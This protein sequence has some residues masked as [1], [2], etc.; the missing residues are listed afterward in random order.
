MNKFTKEQYGSKR[1]FTLLEVM[2]SLAIVAITL[3]VVAGLRNRDIIYHHEIHKMVKATLLA[4][5]RMTLLEIA[6]EYPDFGE[7][8][9]QFEN[10]YEDFSWVQSTVPTPFEFVREIRVVVR[11]GLEPH[12]S[13]LLVSY[14]LE[15]DEI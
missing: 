15:E 4:Q 3:V 8:A 2:V 13:V 1:G 14:G 7:I 5:E 12:E 6:E 11:W 10:P 9:G